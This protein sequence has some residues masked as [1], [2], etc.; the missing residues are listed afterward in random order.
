M[1]VPE[2]IAA[3]LRALP[4]AALLVSR[5]GTIVFANQ[6][7]RE[8]LGGSDAAAGRLLTEVVKDPPEAVGEY[9]RMWARSP[10]PIPGA[11]TLPRRDGGSAVYLAKGALVVP[12]TEDAPALLLVRLDLRDPASPFILLS[13]TIAELRSEVT[14][15]RETEVTLRRT[16]AEL[17]ERAREAEQANQLKDEFLA[18]LSH[19]LR[20]PLNAIIGWVDLIR[21]G[22]LNEP[23]KAH[24]IDVIARNAHMQVQLIDDLLDVSRIVSGKM[25]LNV[26]QLDPITAIEA[27]LEAIRPA[28]DAKGIRLQAVL[29]PQA[30]PISGDPDRLQQV[31]WN[32][33]SNAM[34]FTPKG[35]RIQV[36]L[37]RVDSSIEISVSDTGQGISAEFLPHA[38]ERFR[39]HDG[40][41]TRLHGG[42]GLGLSIVKSLVE[43]H[44]GTVRAESAGPGLGA[45]FVV[46][47][48]RALARKDE[49]ARPFPSVASSVAHPGAASERLDGLRIVVVDDERDAVELIA[50]IL[51]EY[52]ATVTVCRAAAEAFAAIQSAAPDVLISD[53][54]MPDEDGYALIKRIRASPAASG[55]TTPAIALTAFARSED[56]TRALASGFQAH[57]AKPVSIA[58]LVA[59]V[60]SVTYSA[61]LPGYGDRKE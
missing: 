57:V 36:V 3:I 44:G 12:R 27:A 10:T 22:T 56:R 19:E 28:L 49:R 31:V 54:G 16:Q 60:K 32:L 17:R 4:S 7:A 18:A 43:L 46:R 41:S 37:Q 2:P 5:D 52:G 30:G 48:P 23:R 21:S 8:L 42:L 61:R 53:I 47:F 29:D 40:S 1:K 55:G 9:L 20:T 6:T 26:H 34:K 14:R 25:R 58:E 35:G 38:F 59:V 45:T 15:R 50:A 39:Q 24:G 13:Q 11:L 33:L 51:E